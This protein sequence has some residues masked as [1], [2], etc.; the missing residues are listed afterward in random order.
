MVVYMN[1]WMVGLS[2]CAVTLLLM[3]AICLGQGERGSISG[4][5]T[6]ESGAIIPGA[7]VSA[8]NVSTNVSNEAETAQSGTY[9]IPALPP[10][11]YKLIAAKQGFKQALAENVR[12]IVGSTTTIDLKMS[13]GESTQSITVLGE[14]P[15][16]QTTPEVGTDVAPTEVKQ[17]P[18]FLFDMQRQPVDFVFNSLPGTTGGSFQGNINGGQQFGY[19]VEVEGIAIDA[20]YITGGNTDFTP[21]LESVSEFK[22]DTAPNATSGGGGSAVVNYAIKSGGNDYH[23]TVWEFNRNGAL[24]SRGA[25]TNFTGSPKGYRNEHNYGFAGSGPIRKNKTFFFG[26]WEGG[27]KLQLNPAGTVTVPYTPWRSGDF[28]DQLGAQI[29]TDVLGRSVYQGEIFDPTTSRTVNGQIVRDPFTY[30]GRLNVI[31]PARLSNISK[32]I[33]ETIPQ[34]IINRVLDNQYTTDGIPQSSLWTVNAKIDHIFNEKHKISGYYLYSNRIYMN[35][36]GIA[37]IDNPS[38]NLHEF[39][40]RPQAFR[41]SEDW[42]ISPTKLNHAAFGYNRYRQTQA[43]VS[44]GQGWPEKLGLKGV[45]NSTM[46]GVRFDSGNGLN[47]NDV[48]NIRDGFWANGNFVFKDDFTW[49][50]GKHTFQMGG[51]YWQWYYHSRWRSNGSGTFHFNLR[52]TALP[53]FQDTGNQFASFLA[54]AV[55]RAERDV[56]AGEPAYGVKAINFYFQDQVKLTPKLTLTAGIRWNIPRPRTEKTNLLSGLD[57][58]EPNP[59]ADGF[60]GT[61]VFLKDKGRSSFQDSYYKEFAPNFGIAYSLNP[62]TVLRGAYGLNY[63][64]PI[65]LAC[66]RYSFLENFGLTSQAIVSRADAANAFAPALE[67]ENGMPPFSGTLPSKD[68]TLQN[69]GNIAYTLPDSLRQLYY[70]NWTMSVQRELPGQNS[71][72]VSYVGTKGTRLA[73][74]Q[75]AS[76]YAYLPTLYNTTPIRYLSLGDA[77]Y[78]DIGAHPEISKPYPSFQ[79]TVN[80]ALRPFPQYQ[81]V[82]V[83]GL[84]I[85]SSI[86]HS[87]Q[88][89]ARRRPSRGGS[90][91]GYIASY[92]FSKTLTN[93]ENSQGYTNTYAFQWGLQNLRAERAVAFFSFPHDLKITTIWEIPVGKDRHFLNRGGVVNA[94]L[95]GWTLTGIQRYRSGTAL[96]FLDYSIDSS[97]LFFYY[98]GWY[99]DRVP[100]VDVYQKSSGYDLANGSTWI[101][102]A[103]FTHVPTSSLGIPERPGNTPRV[104]DVY[105]PPNYSET[106]GLHKSFPIRE[107]MNFEFRIE[108]QNVFNRTQRGNPNTDLS[109]ENFGKIL[110]VSGTRSVLLSGRFSF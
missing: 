14:T 52:E 60:S 67:W 20:G 56:Y 41:F 61:L 93:A 96:Q 5:I 24:E 6:D 108:A 101:N 7:Q 21:T 90:G 39:N 28:S 55:D 36:G 98:Y 45:D 74:G 91:L 19:E 38:N 57:P 94:I 9:H 25:R 32:G 66:C 51:E 85:G 73:I 2:G 10:G 37:P 23:G 107:R 104:L 84:N 15:L 88:V 11:I 86:Y 44:L 33:T 1:R 53:G 4:T 64:A 97:A 80:Q 110:S 103:A 78:D 58:H 29:G 79:G 26:T 12:V 54:G 69:G 18:V 100:G 35:G 95:G 87:L 40:E 8:T 30:Q 71:L 17:W 92:T 72:E 99:P 48:G 46:P 62:K 68:P 82:S 75:A 70:Q 106:A 65:A 102:P 81:N 49:I 105:G 16:L 76:E 50:A 59:G 77:L 34:P 22:L 43:S 3:V 47:L 63:G 89:Q 27:R 42:T 109:S 31:D 83:T 13:V